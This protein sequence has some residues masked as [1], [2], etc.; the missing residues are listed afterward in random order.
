LKAFALASAIAVNSVLLPLGV[1][2]ADTPPAQPATPV[3]G[4]GQSQA[5]AGMPEKLSDTLRAQTMAKMAAREQLAGIK[6]MGGALPGAAIDGKQPSVAGLK[7][8]PASDASAGIAYVQ[9]YVEPNDYAHRN[10]CGAGATMVLVSHFDANYA[11][12]DI[13]KVGEAINLDP[14]S[15]AWIKDITP[16]VNE[17]LSKLAGREV[18]YYTYGQAASKDEFRWMLDWDIR[19][20]GVPLITGMQTA[21][22]PGWNGYDVGHIVAVNGYWKDA[23]G[24][25]WVSYVDTA[26]PASDYHGDIFV[27]VSLDAFWQAVSQ[28]SAQVW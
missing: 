24:K 9:P 23:S 7:N 5:P 16:A 19:Q 21:T 1:A 10:Y 11:K 12:G 15:G 3:K 20:N 28:N 6:T 25:E 14:D 22:M 17:H 18:K 26:P 8:K 27:T 13:D 2:K 4:A